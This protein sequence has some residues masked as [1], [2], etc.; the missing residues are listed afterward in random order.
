MMKSPE[1]PQSALESS[2]AFV[3]WFNATLLNRNVQF[4]KKGGEMMSEAGSYIEPGMRAT[5]LGGGRPLSPLTKSNVVEWNPANP[6]HNR[7]KFMVSLAGFDVYNKQF[8]SSDFFDKDGVPCLTARE[9]GWYKETQYVYLNPAEIFEL[10]QPLDGVCSD[11]SAL[12]SEYTNSESN[13]T[14]TQ[15]LESQLVAARKG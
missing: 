1:V 14:Y 8:E 9:A 7:I 12:F 4:T 5:I 11:I 3:E 15:W 6:H 10:I 13:L 2:E